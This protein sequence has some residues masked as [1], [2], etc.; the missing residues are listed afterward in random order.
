MIFRG[1]FPLK[2][3]AGIAPTYLSRPDFGSKDLGSNFQFTT[4][5][6]VAV[7]MGPSLRLSYRFQHMSNGGF[8]NPNPGLNLHMIGVSYIF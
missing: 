2:A 3:E 4:H 7:D 1:D 6:G 8:G 5:A